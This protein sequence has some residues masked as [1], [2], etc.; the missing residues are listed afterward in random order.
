MAEEGDA[1][2]PGAKAGIDNGD[3]D[4]PGSILEHLNR[5]P[6]EGAGFF[7]GSYNLFSILTIYRIFTDEHTTDFT[8]T[9]RARLSKAVFFGCVVGQIVFGI[10]GDKIGRSRPLMV[11]CLILVGG[12]LLCS[13]SPF[14]FTFTNTP[15]N[16]F[17]V[18]LFTFFMIS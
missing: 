9:H 11:T 13:L 5:L 10:L 4:R 17:F 15:Q 3:S 14:P 16:K 12:G 2:I 7:V 18:S 8:D 6:V 1:L